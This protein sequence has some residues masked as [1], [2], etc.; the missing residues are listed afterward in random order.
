M[1][2]PVPQS[3]MT[4][5]EGTVRA[6]LGA[7]MMITNVKAT[8]VAVEMVPAG[9]TKTAEHL[10]PAGVNPTKETTTEIVTRVTCLELKKTNYEP[11][12]NV[13]TEKIRDTWQRTAPHT[14]RLDQRAHKCEGL[15]WPLR[16]TRQG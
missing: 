12:T 6:V 9:L 8:K 7:R 3:A 14:I 13:S 5:L 16:Q 4:A 15:P 2:D 11:R 1:I 10:M